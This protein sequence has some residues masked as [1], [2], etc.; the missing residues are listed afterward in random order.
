M[1]GRSRRKFSKNRERETDRER[2]TERQAAYQHAPM[3]LQ[4]DTA[5]DPVAA[6]ELTVAERLQEIEERHLHEPVDVSKLISDD[7]LG[8]R[9]A[10]PCFPLR[11]VL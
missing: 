6:L 2:E 4:H 3:T 10:H 9:K 5:D 8:V 11:E 7:R 1:C